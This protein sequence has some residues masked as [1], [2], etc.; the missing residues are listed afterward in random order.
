VNLSYCKSISDDD[1][2]DLFETW[3]DMNKNLVI[4]IL[5]NTLIGDKAIVKLA[6]TNFIN[7]IQVLRLE[8]C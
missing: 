6:Q 4:L 5:N 7:N 1:F 8:G 2:E 3:T